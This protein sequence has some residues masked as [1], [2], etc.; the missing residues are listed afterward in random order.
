MQYDLSKAT[1]F[2]AGIAQ[3]Y[4]P[5]IFKDIIPA[6][7]YE[8]VDKNLRDAHGY[9]AEAGFRGNANG[10][11]WDVSVFISITKTGWVL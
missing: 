8:V 1:N 3:S 6:S 2:Y 9:T 5:V 7:V 4:R 11:K 10:L